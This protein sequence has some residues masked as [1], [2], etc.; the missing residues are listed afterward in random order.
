MKNNIFFEPP[1]RLQVLDK[2]KHMV[3][4]SDF[5]LLVSGDR[6]AGKSTL[7]DQLK[8]DLNDNTLFCCVVSSET[9]L[10]QEQ[11]L[12]QLLSQLP[13]HDEVEADFSSRLKAFYL[14]LKAFRESGQKCLIIVDDAENLSANALELLLNLHQADS[15]AGGAQLLLLMNSNFAGKLLSSKPVKLLEGRVHHL[16]LTKMTEEETKEYVSLCHPAAASLSEK[17]LSQLIQLAEGL[18]GRVDKLI[19]GDK[20]STNSSTGARAFPLPAAHM[21]G[22]GLI[23]VGILAVSLWQFFPEESDLSENAVS[24]TVSVP[25]PVPA[26]KPKNDEVVSLTQKG[27]VNEND[28]TTKSITPAPVKETS[29]AQLELE[30]RLALQ[31][32]KIEDQKQE[33]AEEPVQK[34]EEKQ[35]SR[36]AEELREVVKTANSEASTTKTK[37]IAEAPPSMKVAEKAPGQEVKQEKP[38]QEVVEKVAQEVAKPLSLPKTSKY[39]ASENTILAWKSSGYTLQLLG[40]RSKKS[41]LDFIS[42]QKGSE[43]FYYFS[44]IY[45]GAPW[46]VVIYGE[47]ANRDIANSA[48]KKLPSELRKMRPWAR[49]VRG[50]QID[51]KKK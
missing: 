4:F 37:E 47:F 9:G 29:A 26:S 30:R 3:R 48:I 27:S 35:V 25:L 44:T 49:S 2:L 40:A 24:E 34:D 42:K 14:Q 41:A 12:D 50:V 8:P 22:I 13:L 33:T 43:Q 46:H 17:K 19:A 6:G 31:E 18:P 45:K 36:I 38:K 28:S 32:K 5:L 21:G 16:E 15:S 23:L 11:L 51:I 7:V 39:S 1:S 10:E 20:V